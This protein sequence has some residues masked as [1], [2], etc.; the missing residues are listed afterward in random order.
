[1]TRPASSPTTVEDFACTFGL[2]VGP[3]DGDG[4]ELFYVTVCTPKHLEKLCKRDGFVWGRHYLIVPYFDLEKIRAIFSKFVNNC[5]GQTWHEIGPK[6]ARF[7]SR[8]FEARG[9]S[10]P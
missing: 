3:K 2:T 6:L 8:E 10:A 1:M 9:P 5:S 4:G 7:E